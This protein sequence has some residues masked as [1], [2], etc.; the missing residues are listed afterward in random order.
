M[1]ESAPETQ[2]LTSRLASNAAN[3]CCK[4]RRFVRHVRGLH[5]VRSRLARRARHC[6][7]TDDG[8]RATPSE[9]PRVH[10]RLCPYGHACTSTEHSSDA[11]ID[12]RCL[13]DG[14]RAS[15][16]TRAEQRSRSATR[17]YEA[18]PKASRPP[19]DD[20]SKGPWRSNVDSRPPDERQHSGV[21]HDGAAPERRDVRTRWRRLVHATSSP[22]CGICR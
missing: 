4:S 21:I 5:Q 17:V 22:S 10:V 7:T 20:V 3:F 11:S 15:R 18:P 9:R 19:S 1:R 12:P 16:A 13:R 2:R 8:Q 6:A 14:V